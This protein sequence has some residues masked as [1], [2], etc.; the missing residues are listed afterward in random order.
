MCSQECFVLALIYLDR[1]TQIS[2]A[3]TINDFNIHRLIITSVVIAAKFFDDHYFSNSHYAKVGGITNQELNNLEFEFLN[4]IN[5]SLYVPSEQFMLY[6]NKIQ[7][8]KEE[9]E[10]KKIQMENQV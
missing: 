1:I 3:Y 6:Q 8:I 7:E 5:Y 2:P 4:S 9:Y 10:K